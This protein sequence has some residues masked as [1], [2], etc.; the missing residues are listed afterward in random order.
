MYPD[1]SFSLLRLR[2]VADA[3]PAALGA[4]IQRFQNLNIAPRRISAEFGTD[5]LLH[6]EVDVCGMTEEQ[7]SLI[8]NKIAESPCIHRTHWHPLL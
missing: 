3:D 5:D 8:A 7:L 4:V 2:V 1:E 6:I